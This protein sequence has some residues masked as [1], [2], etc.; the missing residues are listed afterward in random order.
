MVARNASSL[1]AV[2]AMLVGVKRCKRYYCHCY[3]TVATHGNH[4]FWLP[5]CASDLML[6][7]SSEVGDLLGCWVVSGDGGKEIMAV[8]VKCYNGGCG[9]MLMVDQCP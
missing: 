1:S 3:T 4:R 8:V 6:Y 5:H 7:W 9:G 2:A